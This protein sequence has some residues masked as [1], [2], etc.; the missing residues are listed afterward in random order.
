MQPKF[1]KMLY[2]GDYNPNQWPKEIWDEDMKLF[3]QAGINSTTI[4]VFSWAKIQPSENEYDFT[5]L[6]EIVD[7]L[8]KE[9]VQIVMATSTGALPAWMV[10]R[11]PEVART[12]FEGRHHKFGHR[13]NACPNSPVFQ[14][15]AKRLA[16]K[17]AERY[18]DNKNIVCWHISNEYG[19]E[20]YCEN[21]AKAFRS[22][23]GMEH[24]VLGAHHLRLGRDCTAERSGRRNAMGKRHCICRNVPRLHA[25]Q[26]RRHAEQLQNGA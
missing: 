4:N 21:C 24:G 20:C 11:Y 26:L 15:Y 16:E 1:K 2:G 25:F 12:D 22:Q 8:T 3:H 6:D 18:G 23:Q 9:D 19:G 5:E 13:H 10:H 17:L 14:K 7:T